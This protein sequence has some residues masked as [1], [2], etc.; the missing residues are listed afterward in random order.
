[1]PSR[2]II[3]IQVSLI[4]CMFK[5]VSQYLMKNQPHYRLDKLATKYEMF[6][7][8]KRVNLDISLLVGWGYILADASC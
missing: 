7:M 3:N 2:E 1:M 5:S 8:L 6:L 4:L